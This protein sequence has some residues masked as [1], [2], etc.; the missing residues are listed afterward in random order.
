MEGGGGGTSETN[1]RATSRTCACQHL[2]MNGWKHGRDINVHEITN[3][4]KFRGGH[5]LGRT[6]SRRVSPDDRHPPLE[7]QQ[8]FTPRRGRMYRPSTTVV[9]AGCVRPTAMP[10]ELGVSPCHDT[11]VRRCPGRIL[12]NP[13]T[14]QMQT[15]P[16]ISRRSM[17]SQ[18]LCLTRSTD[19]EFGS[20][21][22]AIGSL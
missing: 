12:P 11:V 17:M 1:R 19:L 2:G 10:A 15:V 13:R 22:V 6:R 7:L 16:A 4:V 20:S 9:G 3:H 5:L 21:S 8:E 18:W 14:G